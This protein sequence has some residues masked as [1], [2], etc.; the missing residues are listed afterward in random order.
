[1][2]EYKVGYGAKQSESGLSAVSLRTCG[3]LALI[4]VYGK[5]KRNMG[6]NSDRKMTAV[7]DPWV[8]GQ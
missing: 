2:A 1:M 6:L 8:A 5:K 3:A 4:P 7:R